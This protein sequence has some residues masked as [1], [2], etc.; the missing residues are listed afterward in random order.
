MQLWRLI[1]SGHTEQ[2]LDCAARLRLTNLTE[3]QAIVGLSFG[4]RALLSLAA[5]RIDRG[6][7][8]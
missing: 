5:E 2:G 8:T 7:I 1:R 6:L 3:N 4:T